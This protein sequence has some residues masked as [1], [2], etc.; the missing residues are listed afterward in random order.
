MVT[1]NNNKRNIDLSRILIAHNFYQLPGGEDHV[2]RAE[3]QLLETHGHEVI[4][5]TVRNDAIERQGRLKLACRT[6]WNKKA[7][8]DLVRLIRLKKPQLVHF[9]N[10]LP[11]I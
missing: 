1:F 10:T 6:V 11:L 4:P 2:F 3:T 8:A 7:A 9:H 5:Y